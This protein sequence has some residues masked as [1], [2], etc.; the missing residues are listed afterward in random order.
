VRCLCGSRKEQWT[1]PAA[2]A[3]VIGVGAGVGAAPASVDS[4]HNLQRCVPGECKQPEE[5]QAPCSRATEEEGDDVALGRGKLSAEAWAAA[6]A[7]RAELRRR[8]RA[9]EE[10]QREVAR[11]AVAEQRQALAAAARKRS[12][13]LQGVFGVLLA[14]LVLWLVSLVVSG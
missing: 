11:A 2:R 6:K 12:L 10:E 1:C 3:A 13:T 8:R 14:A 4:R 7:E 9:V 5:G